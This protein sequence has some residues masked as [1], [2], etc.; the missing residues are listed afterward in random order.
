MANRTRALH[1]ARRRWRQAL[2][3]IG[4]ELREA[5]LAL[6]LSQVHVG[7]ALGVSRSQISRLEQGRLQRVPA[8]RLAEHAAVVG[9]RLW[10]KLYPQGGALR[11]AAQTRYVERFLERVAHGWRVTLDAPI[12][13]PADLRAV[14]VL[15]SGAACVIAVEVI[16][17]LRDLQA[18]LRS[19]QQ[20]GR[21]MGAQRL[22]LVVAGSHANRHALAEARGALLASFDL[23]TRRVMAALAAGRDPGRDAIVVL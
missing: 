11:D 1:E 14:D 22:I 3:E 20:K 13:L 4:S 6:G 2:A 17:R 8:E 21:D 5:R 23:D 15:L 19:A 16:T 12:P 10:F 18:Q 9:L 7:T